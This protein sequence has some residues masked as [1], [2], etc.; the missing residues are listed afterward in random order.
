[1]T[2]LEEAKEWNKTHPEN[3]LSAFACRYPGRY[4]EAADALR[5][6]RKED[7]PN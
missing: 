3:S 5:E 4:G 7:N 1:M 2:L 6:V